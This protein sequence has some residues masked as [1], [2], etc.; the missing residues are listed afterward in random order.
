MILI[1]ARVGRQAASAGQPFAATAWFAVGY[2]LSWTSQSHRRQGSERARITAPR[3]GQWYAKS[4]SNVLA[5]ASIELRA[6][7]ALASAALSKKTSDTV[8]TIQGSARCRYPPSRA[9]LTPIWRYSLWRRLGAPRVAVTNKALA[10]AYA[11]NVLPVIRGM[12]WAG[13]TSLHQ[14]ADALNARGITTP[15]GGQWYAKSV[16]NVLARA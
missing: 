13:A 3:G 16:S 12:R 14:I 10:D 1:Y 4:V 2:L 7:R 9:P 5:R 15:R 11:A 8:G 6:W